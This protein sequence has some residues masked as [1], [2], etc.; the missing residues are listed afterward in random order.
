MFFQGTPGAGRARKDTPVSRV[1][2]HGGETAL[3][4]VAARRE[5]G[6]DEMRIGKIERPGIA[7]LL[8]VAIIG[9]YGVYFPAYAPSL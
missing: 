6:R 4:E 5:Q 8:Q 1:Q 2:D 7:L 3:G 9:I